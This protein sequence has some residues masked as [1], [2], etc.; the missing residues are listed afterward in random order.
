MAKSVICVGFDVPGSAA[1][2]SVNH[3]SQLSVLDADIVVFNPDVSDYIRNYS[4]TYQGKPSLDDNASFQLSENVRRWRNELLTAV[5]AGKTVIV[6]MTRAPVVVVDTGQRQYSG[7]GRNRFTARMVTE[8]D[9]YSAIPTDLGTVV[10]AGGERMK[11]VEDLGVLANYWHDFAAYSKYE[12]Y[13]DGYKGKPRV[14]T[15]VGDKAVAVMIRPQSS[16]GALILLPPPNLDKMAA[17]TINAL[18]AGAEKRASKSAQA[19]TLHT[20]KASEIVGAKFIAALRELDKAVHSETETSPPLAWVGQE[21]FV[22][23]EEADI[24]TRLAENEN[25]ISAL[26]QE[27]EDLLGKLNDAAALKNLLFEKGKPLG[28]DD[29]AVNIDKLDQLDRNVREDFQRLGVTEYAKGVLFGNASRF[30]APAERGPFF[31]EKCLTGAKRSGVALVRTPDL[32]AVA[33]YLKEHDDPQFA[34]ECRK[35]ILETNGEI[36]SFPPVPD[37]ADSKAAG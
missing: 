35:A 28:K 25:K 7:T 9:P 11:A 26:H 29:K 4:D 27:R 19:I 32:F 17:E 30:T 5:N 24:V 16:R 20:E 13:L 18:K 6:M 22:L 33:R 34:L 8:L 21:Q 2:K 14:V 23:N 37:V 15:Q 12:V 10:R 1:A 31:T 3:K 36:V